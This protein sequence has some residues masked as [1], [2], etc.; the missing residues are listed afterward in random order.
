MCANATTADFSSKFTSTGRRLFSRLTPKTRNLSDFH[1]R[2]DEPHRQYSPGDIVKGAV[3]LTVVKPIRITHLTVALHGFVRV[4]KRPN[5]EGE[6]PGGP[7]L[8]QGS[9]RKSQYF[10]NGH[11]SLFQDE[12]TLC[13]EGRLDVGV[14]EFNFELDF[15]KKGLPSSIDVSAK[16]ALYLPIH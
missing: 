10:G 11:A 7:G 8:V 16:P 4:Y 5:G 9:T 1:V 2:L 3:I 14:Y 6:S 12:V 15:P 13:G